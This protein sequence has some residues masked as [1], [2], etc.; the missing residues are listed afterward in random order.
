MN[1][2]LRLKLA[3]LRHMMTM[4]DHNLA[5]SEDLLFS[6][7]HAVVAPAAGVHEVQSLLVELEKENRAIRIVGDV[8]RFTPTARGRA[9][10]SE[11]G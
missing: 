4:D 6:D 1:R 5:S 9:F 8:V 2:K 3:L 11:N 7:C 10:V